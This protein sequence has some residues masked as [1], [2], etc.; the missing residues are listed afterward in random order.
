MPTLIWITE[1]FL[2][3]TVGALPT[4]NIMAP[5]N[6]NTLTSWTWVYRLF[7]IFALMSR[8]WIYQE[9]A[10]SS[11]TAFGYE[12]NTP[13]WDARLAVWATPPLSI[14]EECCWLRCLYALV[15]Q[16]AGHRGYR[17]ELRCGSETISYSWRWY[18]HRPKVS[19]R[20]GIVKLFLDE[21]NY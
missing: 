12:G 16:A 13:T 15:S 5:V 10:H 7:N 21:T 11:V 4:R 8:S 14:S 20:P 9:T 2:F 17:W 6:L 3:G 19:A 18:S 1:R